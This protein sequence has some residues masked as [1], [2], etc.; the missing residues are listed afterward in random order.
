MSLKGLG[1][2]WGPPDIIFV[3]FL[4]QHSF[5]ILKIYPQKTRKSQHFKP[6]ILRFWCFHSFNW[7]PL[8]DNIYGMS[9]KTSGACPGHHLGHHFGHVWGIILG[10]SGASSDTCIGHHLGHVWG[11]SGAS[12]GTC[13]GHVPKLININLSIFGQTNLD[14]KCRFLCGIGQQF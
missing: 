12:S 13:L 1:T 6:K 14:L 2:T 8:E 10:M 4:H 5:R 3:N 7:G 11:M 9:G